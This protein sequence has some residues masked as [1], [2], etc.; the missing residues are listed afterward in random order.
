MIFVRFQYVEN[1]WQ[2]LELFHQKK[3]HDEIITTTLE[4]SIIPLNMVKRNWKYYM[5]SFCQR[6]KG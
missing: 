4:N 5:C 3:I 1:L 6:E 2:S